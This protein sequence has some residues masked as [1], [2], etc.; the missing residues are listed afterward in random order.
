VRKR[1]TSS[2]EMANVRIE[3]L[4]FGDCNLP[5]QTLCSTRIVP[6]FQSMPFSFKPASSPGRIPVSAR[7]QKNA[8]HFSGAAAMIAIDS[9][10]EKL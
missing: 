1:W 2:N 4:V 7:S 3:L 8:F 5:C 10:T 9:S 6:A